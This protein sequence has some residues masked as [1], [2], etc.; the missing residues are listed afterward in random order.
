MFRIMLHHMGISAAWILDPFVR[1]HT[2]CRVRASFALE[3]DPLPVTLHWCREVI[4]NKHVL[5][6]SF[7]RQLASTHEGCSCGACRVLLHVSGLQVSRSFP[8]QFP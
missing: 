8:A 1:A 3:M 5:K 4:T 2:A 7:Q 6:N